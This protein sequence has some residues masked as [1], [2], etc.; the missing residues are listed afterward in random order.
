MFL[1][2]LI[3]T[4]EDNSILLNTQ[5]NL[6]QISFYNPAFSLHRLNVIPA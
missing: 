6:V 3:L 1:R 2:H 5:I 4:K